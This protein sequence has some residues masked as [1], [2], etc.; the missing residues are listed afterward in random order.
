MSGILDSTIDFSVCTNDNIRKAYLV[1]KYGVIPDVDTVQYVLKLN[2]K[3]KI[4][5]FSLFSAL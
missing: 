3:R 2:K 5:V 4:L 1:G